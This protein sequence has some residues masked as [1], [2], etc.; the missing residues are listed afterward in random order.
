MIKKIHLL[1]YPFLCFFLLILLFHDFYSLKYLHK[2]THIHYSFIIPHRK[3]LSSKFDFTPFLHHHRHRTA[4][5]LPPPAG[6]FEID[7]RYDVEK[8]IVPSGPNP[9]HH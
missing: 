3:A 8:R 7:P 2:T 9:L 1:F 5:R 4:G 6:G